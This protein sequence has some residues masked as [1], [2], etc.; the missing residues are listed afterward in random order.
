MER[1]V[2]T[3]CVT[4]KSIREPIQRPA[5]FSRHAQSDLL[6]SAQAAV[7]LPESLPHR[8][9]RL[10]SRRSDVLVTAALLAETVREI[11]EFPFRFIKAR[12]DATLNSLLPRIVPCRRS[13]TPL[14]AP[15]FKSLYAKLLL[16]PNIARSP[17][18][19]TNSLDSENGTTVNPPSFT[20]CC[21]FIGI[22]PK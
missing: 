9:M 10:R 19:S 13:D 11:E 8:E 22:P 5:R 15:S 18:R 3:G 12:T 17:S 7:L 21:F 16:I 14:I 1:C 20:D 6:V 4:L 2:L